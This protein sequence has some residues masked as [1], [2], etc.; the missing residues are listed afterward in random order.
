MFW[1]SSPFIFSC[2]SPGV[3]APML[4]H[5]LTQLCLPVDCADHHIILQYL[6]LPLWPWVSHQNTRQRTSW[7]PD[8][9]LQSL[10]R[11]WYLTFKKMG[12]LPFAIRCMNLEDITLSEIS[13]TQKDKRRVTPLGW[14]VGQRVEADTGALVAWAR[15]RGARGGEP[16]SAGK[17]HKHTRCVVSRRLPTTFCPQLTIRYESGRVRHSVMSDSLQPHGL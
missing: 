14:K 10:Q 11:A 4:D 5:G 8:L 6:C 13:Q 9:K 2:S 17:S 3:P 1:S 7:G 15:E 16:L 12:N